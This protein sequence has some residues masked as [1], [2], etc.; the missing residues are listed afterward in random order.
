[1]AAM[2]VSGG[3]EVVYV[4]MYGTLDGGGNAA[5]HVFS[6]SFNPASGWSAWQDLTLNPVTAPIAS[7]LMISQNHGVDISSLYIDPHD[8]S[9]QTVYVT[10]AELSNVFDL[11]PTVYRSTKGGASWAN[12]TA[13]LPSAPANSLVVDPQ[14]RQHG[15]CWHRR[16][17]IFYHADWE[18]REPGG[19]LLVGVLG[20][21]CRSRRWW[22]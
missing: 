18:L 20:L 11:V 10:V 7:G 4:G 1:M 3:G 2:A 16:G 13:N 21:D 5:G 15:V 19:H 12:V 22:N 8:L 14:Q 6:A 17:G 9:G